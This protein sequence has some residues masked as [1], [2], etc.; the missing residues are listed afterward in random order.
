MNTTSSHIKSCPQISVGDVV[1]FYNIKVRN[2]KRE[3]IE[4][5]SWSGL[6]WELRIKYDWYFKYRAA[7][8]QVKYPKFYV[9][10]IWGNE[11]PNQKTFEQIRNNKIKSKKAKIT[12]YKNKLKL[13]ELNWNSLF[14]IEEDLYYQKAIEKIEKLEKELHS[15]L[16]EIQK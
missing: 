16:Q 4:V 3:I 8:L 12:E 13:A 15:Y 11:L 1:H 10:S 9:E 5:L 7:L 2:N 6:S 14:P